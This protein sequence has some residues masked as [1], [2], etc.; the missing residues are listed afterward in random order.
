MGSLARRE[1]WQQLKY[2]IFVLNSLLRPVS[3]FLSFSKVN[4]LGLAGGVSKLGRG[5]V[6]DVKEGKG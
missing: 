4:P 2:Y 1:G 5:Q 6:A 3:F